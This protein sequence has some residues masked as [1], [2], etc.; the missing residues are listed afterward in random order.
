L[1]QN[2]AVAGFL[3]PQ[4][5]HFTSA[6]P[7]GKARPKVESSRRGGLYTQDSEVVNVQ[8]TLR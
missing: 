3:F 2:L 8:R 4:L 5:A 6:S 7:R 1:E